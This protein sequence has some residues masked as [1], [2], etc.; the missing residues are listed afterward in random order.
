MPIQIAIPDGWR[1]EVTSSNI[2]VFRDHQPE[3]QTSYVWIDEETPESGDRTVDDLLRDTDLVQASRVV[4]DGLPALRGY[5]PYP[6]G[7]IDYGKEDV[8]VFSPEA[9]LYLISYQCPIPDE[10]IV[11][12]Q[13]VSRVHFN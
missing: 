8:E 13:I 1:V 6:Y 5:S 3:A 10:R 7:Q 9:K 12:D 11:C 2:T 4:I